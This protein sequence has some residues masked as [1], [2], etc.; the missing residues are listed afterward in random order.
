[1]Q[2]YFTEFIGTFFLVLTIGLAGGAE[3]DHFAFIAVGAMMTALVYMGWHIS[4]AHFNPAITLG[5]FIRKGIDIKEA[6]IY[7]GVQLIAGLAAAALAG[8][9][10]MDDSFVFD[11]VRPGKGDN[12]IKAVL[13][14]TLLTYLLTLVYLNVARKESTGNN[15]YYGLAIGFTV[16]AISFVGVSISGGA[17]NPA[18][19]IG[20]NIVSAQFGHIWIYIVGPLLGGALAGFTYHFLYPKETA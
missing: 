14:E 5:V 15:S 13:V 17:F 6:G 9:L 11:F 2:K 19:G 18:V 20:P 7:W 4:G 1:M 16:L 3:H 10:I 12:L 8:I